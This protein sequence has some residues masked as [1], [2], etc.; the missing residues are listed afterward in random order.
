MNVV[1]QDSLWCS[2]R[3]GVDFALFPIMILTA[4]GQAAWYSMLPEL[5]DEKA[6]D[7]DMPDVVQDALQKCG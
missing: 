5:A 4:Y 2:S 7:V 6:P 3:T 1:Q